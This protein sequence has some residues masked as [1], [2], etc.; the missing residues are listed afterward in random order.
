MN[1]GWCSVKERFYKFIPDVL[2]YIIYAG[3]NYRVT[4]NIDGSYRKPR[5][6]Y[7]PELVSGD[8]HVNDIYITG[9]WL[10]SDLTGKEFKDYDIIIDFKEKDKV[11]AF[12]NYFKRLIAILNIYSEDVKY[13]I[14]FKNKLKIT[15]KIADLLFDIYTIYGTLQQNVRQYHFPLVRYLYSLYHERLYCYQSF[16]RSI[17]TGILYNTRRLCFFDETIIYK[18]Y[19][20]YFQRGWAHLLNKVDAKKFC[21]HLDDLKIKYDHKSYETNIDFKR[22]YAKISNKKDLVID[23]EWKY[24]SN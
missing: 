16:I 17:T 5:S 19:T 6:S 8:R 21:K 2:K 13:E 20:K 7:D 12:T 4:I 15:I 1:Q 24:I 18:I 11:K 23:R 22:D 3:A 14:I 9:S 10:S